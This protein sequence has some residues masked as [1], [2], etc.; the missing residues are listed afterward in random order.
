MSEENKNLFVELPESYTEGDR[1]AIQ[2]L[3]DNCHKHDSTISL[4]PIEYQNEINDMILAKGVGKGLL[5]IGIVGLIGYGASKVVERFKK[6]HI[7]D[8]FRPF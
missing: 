8:T 5:G 3:I 6:R 2:H 7:K 4:T 1:D